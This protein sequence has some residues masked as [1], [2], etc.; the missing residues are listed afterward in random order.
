MSGVYK[1]LEHLPNS[2]FAQSNIDS[3]N[4]ELIQELERIRD[5]NVLHYLTGRSDTP[6]WTT[7][8]SMTLP[9]SLAQAIDL[10][11][12]RPSSLQARRTVHRSVLVLRF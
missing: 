3:Y 4:T 5:F 1:L 10:P 7:S 11:A 2:S 12:H 8:R 9:D 6:L